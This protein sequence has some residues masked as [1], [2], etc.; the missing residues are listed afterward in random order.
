LHPGASLANVVE[1]N[2]H[3]RTQTPGIQS[4]ASHCSDSYRYVKEH[5]SS[6]ELLIAKGGS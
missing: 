2:S 1:K 4:L 6:E 3:F 5:G